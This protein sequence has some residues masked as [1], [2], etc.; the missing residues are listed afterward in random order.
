MMT[1]LVEYTKWIKNET[2]P[3]FDLGKDEDFAF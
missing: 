1:V 3:L 2:S